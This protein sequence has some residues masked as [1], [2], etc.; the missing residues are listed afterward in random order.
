MWVCKHCKNRFIGSY[1]CIQAHF[2]GPTAG[3]KPE[4]GRCDLTSNRLEFIA[5]RRMVE[6]AK[7]TGVP[8]FLKTSTT[9][10]KQSVGVA[11]MKPIQAT[12]NVMDVSLVRLVKYKCRKIICGQNTIFIEVRPRLLPLPTCAHHR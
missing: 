7:K 4:I 8:S 1:T 10:K 12:F 5:L 11:A 9:T 3:K 2:F 6:E